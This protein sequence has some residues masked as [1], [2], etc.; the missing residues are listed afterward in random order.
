VSGAISLARERR[1]LFGAFASRSAEDDEH[2]L[3]SEIEGTSLVDHR[4]KRSPV[5]CILA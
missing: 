2:N 1:G 5:P 4:A 3:L